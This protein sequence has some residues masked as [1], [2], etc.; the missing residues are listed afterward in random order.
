MTEVYRLS[1]AGDPFLSQVVGHDNA[2]TDN[3]PPFIATHINDQCER[4][5]QKSGYGKHK[6]ICLRV[7]GRLDRRSQAQ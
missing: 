1:T 6:V 4:H 3:H 7:E 5:H 2:Q